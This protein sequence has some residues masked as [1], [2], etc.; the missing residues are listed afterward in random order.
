MVSSSSETSL[1]GAANLFLSGS[2]YPSVPRTVLTVEVPAGMWPG[3]ITR[4]HPAIT[5]EVLSHLPLKKGHGLALV[6]VTG[7]GAGEIPPEISAH[8]SVTRVHTIRSVPGEAN[9]L[10]EVKRTP[11]LS[12]LMAASILPATPFI[13]REGYADWKI[14]SGEKEITSLLDDLR[15][16]GISNRIRYIGGREEPLAQTIQLTDRQRSILN[17]AINAG[18]YEVPRRTS[19]TALARRL[20]I[21]KSSLSETLQ[22]IERKIVRRVSGEIGR[23]AEKRE[24]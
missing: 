23:T 14:V 20:G 15:K 6:R 22:V 9:L 10:I 24:A 4:L 16:R 13:V 18:Y 1:V 2:G 11:L 19:M 7:T 17:E 12:A 21:G 5:I 8:P 3:D